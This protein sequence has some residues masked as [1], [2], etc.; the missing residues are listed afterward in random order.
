LADPAMA[1]ALFNNAEQD[2]GPAQVLVNNAAYGAPDT[3]PPGGLEFA[4]E[5]LFL[6]R[7]STRFVPGSRIDRFWLW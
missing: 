6:V 4:T 5:D 7:R 1:P 2:L 3:F